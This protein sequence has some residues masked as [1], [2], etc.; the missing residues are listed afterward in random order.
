MRFGPLGRDRHWP[1]ALGI[2]VLAS[3]TPP[4]GYREIGAY[5]AAGYT[6]YER[7]LPLARAGEPKY[8]NLMGFMTFFGE[9]APADWTEAH[10][11][12]HLAADQGYLPAQRNLAI[13]HWLGVGPLKDRDEAQHYARSGGITNLKQLVAAFSEAGGERNSHPGEKLYVTFCAGCHGLNGIAA[14]V[15]SPSFALGDRLEKPDGVLLYSIHNGKGVMPGW[16]GKLPDNRFHDVLDFVRG[17]EEQ[18][19]A[20]IAQALRRAP[21]LYFLFGPMAENHIAYRTGLND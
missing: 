13:I 14:Y 1:G 17:L 3:C 15:D 6:T 18:Y 9:G 19:Q 5:A 8:Q 2:L 16:G 4:P 10:L 21:N 7:Y 20:G 12:F 11:W